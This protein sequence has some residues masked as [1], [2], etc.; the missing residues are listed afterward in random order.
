MSK[1]AEYLPCVHPQ[2]FPICLR[3]TQE[4]HLL[5]TGTV[6]FSCVHYS[7]QLQSIGPHLLVRKQLGKL[8]RWTECGYVP[9]PIL[10][11]R[12]PFSRLLLI[13]TLYT[14][15]PVIDWC[16]FLVQHLLGTHTKATGSSATCQLG[17]QLWVLLCD[18]NLC[19]G[20]L[21]I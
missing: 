4:K 18:L 17:C 1:P 19:S 3:K 11:Q 12:H 15:W 16:L 20:C 10:N 8:P 14:P 21:S 2:K 7:S 9:H 6:G 13:R 5:Y